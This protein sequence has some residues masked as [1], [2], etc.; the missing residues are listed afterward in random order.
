MNQVTSED[1]VNTSKLNAPRFEYGKEISP[2]DDLA[3]D[4]YQVLDDGL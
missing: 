3:F 1:E 4:M 2:Y